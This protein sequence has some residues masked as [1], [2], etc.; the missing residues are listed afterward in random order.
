M[1]GLRAP[2]G[3]CGFRFIKNTSAKEVME[4]M[5]ISIGIDI[6]KKKCDCC[7]VNGRGRVLERG[8]YFNAQKAAKRCA[9]MML[10]RYGKMGNCTAACGTTANVWIATVGAFGHVGIATKPANSHRMTLINKTGKKTDRID[11][12]KIAQVLRMDMMPECHMPS[13][14]IRGI[15][16]MVR[17]HVRP[18]QAR[19]GAVNQVHNLLDAHGKAVHASNAYSD[20]APPCLGAPSL[21]DAQD[22]FVLQRCVRRIRHYTG[23]ITEIDRQSETEAS[24]SE[25]AKPP[26]GVT[27][28]GPHTAILPAAEIS[29]I[30]RFETPKKMASWAGLCPTVRQPGNGM[31]LGRIK[32]T[33]TDGPVNRAMCGAAGAAAKHDTRM[34][35]TYGHARRRHANRRTL[36][37]V[38]AAHR[39]IATM[40]HVPKTKTPYESRNE[41]PY[42]RKPARLEK[43]RQSEA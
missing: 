32:K 31:R 34:K 28:I 10:G 23:E 22:G 24:Q 25:C 29:G 9:K 35:S 38:V 27:G 39:M 30:S 21:G 43:R 11:A 2:I 17:R 13:M 16:N 18:V 4:R 14:H 12:E 42:N 3:V 41:D 36:A 7:M 8:Q 40:W 37:I 15:R 19:T 1:A 6:G 33:G 5:K 20:K 26:A